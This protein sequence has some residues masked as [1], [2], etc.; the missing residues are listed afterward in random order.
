MYLKFA[1]LLFMIF[2]NFYY[3]Y[4]GYHINSCKNTQDFHLHS[5][6]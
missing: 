3:I 5:D 6:V 4:W 2:D 1:I